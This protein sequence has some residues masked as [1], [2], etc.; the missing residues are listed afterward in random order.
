MPPI[1]QVNN[2]VQRVNQPEAIGMVLEH[3]QDTQTNT[4]KYL[5][6]FGAEQRVVPE[7]GLRHL[8][9]RRTP[10]DA[11]ADGSFSG[12][13]HFVFTLTFH[14]LRY[15]PTRIA[16]SF[17]TARTQFFPHQFKPLL[18]FLENPGKRL[19]IA[20]DVGLGKTIE[21]GYILRELDARQG[22]LDRVLV[23]VPARL[24]RKW[25][26]ELL[27]RFGE[28]FDII[29]G[30]QVIQ[31][32]ERARQGRELDTF[33]WILSY[34]SARVDEVEN[35]IRET[36]LPIDLLIADE[37]HR[38][39]NSDTL[40]H[41]VGRALCSC[42]D[43][44]L[45]LTAT[46]VQTSMENL[47]ILFRL[48]SPT[49]FPRWEL[50][51]AQIRAN[52]D[53]LRAQQALAQ[54]QPDLPKAREFMQLFIEEM[55]LQGVQPG[56][57]AKSVAQRLEAMSLER[58]QVVE[59]QGDLGLLS[60]IG[61]IL[62]RTRKIDA[63]ANRPI[64][65]AGWIKVRLSQEERAIYDSV[66]DVCRQAWGGSADWGFHMS[67]LMAYRMTASCI[68]AAIEYF[69]DKLAGQPMPN[70]NGEEAEEDDR[71]TNQTAWTTPNSRRG[72][73]CAIDLYT[74][75]PLPDT[76][77]GELIKVIH[78][79]WEADQEQE[80][81]R[82]K[83]VVFSFFRRTL[84]YLEVALRRANVENRMIRGGTLL[85]DR[86]LAIDTFL[87][88]DEVNVLLT[89]EVGGEGIDLQKACVVINY[90][91]PWNPMVVEQRIGRVDRIGQESPVI[92]IFNFVVEESVEERILARLLRRIDIFRESVGELDDIIGDQIEELTVKALSGELNDEELE[93]LVEQ[94]G[95]AVEHR[96]H[97]A[98]QM[99]SKVDGLLAA[100]Q[101]LID[102]VNAVVGERQLPNEHELLLFLNR[103]LATKYTGVQLPES[104]T[105]NV[106]DVD[107]RGSLAT[108]MERAA[109]ELGEDALLLA[110]R[111]GTGSL[112]A[113]LSRD[114]AFRHHRAEL[115]HLQ[116]P[117]TRFAVLGEKQEPHPP[118]AFAL[119][120]P[121]SNV[122]AAGRY[123]FL[124]ALLHFNTFQRT[125]KLV[126]L[127]YDWT[128]G[129]LW[130][131]PEETTPILI[132]LLEAGLDD[133]P[134]GLTDADIDCIKP[135]LLNGIQ[136][137]Q[138]DWETRERRSEQARAEQRQASRAASF[139]FRIRAAQERL[140]ILQGAGAHD[141]PIRM[142]KG[143][144][145]KAIR[146]RDA[147]LA[148][149]VE[150]HWGGAEHEEI[151]VGI[152]TV[153]E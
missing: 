11:I 24:T 109:A 35:A 58:R 149:P 60:P 56:K 140:T 55:T 48:L 115:I 47:W 44:V 38:M 71:D 112:A 21:A 36:Q 51:E 125:T 88:R 103:C 25:R 93:L 49:E 144:L 75:S 45:F 54:R 22:R 106:T 141:F 131:N 87:L 99:L 152:L 102:E 146:E 62:S 72:F 119:A 28:H 138:Q 142:A 57:F 81:K 89:S 73:Q 92:Y 39:R 27:N 65:D 6:Q 133:A 46:P 2:V 113:T 91:L 53:L 30:T 41:R 84:A 26:H 120:L 137:L 18:K 33:R 105:R 14:R 96:V 52:R 116:H 143:Q 76:K 132:E 10:W 110:R 37:A 118:T 124:I 61:H 111:M 128:N 148:Q 86:E 114:A 16:N 94:Q 12:R 82:R 83:V 74:R 90:D 85:E 78:R 13:D 134:P 126:A 32:A 104:L 80:R 70:A 68:P 20:D 107:L 79:L 150:N 43:S 17:A 1:F 97:E 101:A 147:F 153:R 69:N 50:F 136:N 40:Q 135:Q 42:A 108:D 8:V 66:E 117:L 19:L 7:E 95:Q 67:L 123:A 4:W 122:L 151:T 31:Q 64:R 121:R 100:D 77:L 15:P 29:K 127:F 34:E 130:A 98:R 129:H 9:V 145:D 139:E 59:L 63:L 23:L 5:V 3:R